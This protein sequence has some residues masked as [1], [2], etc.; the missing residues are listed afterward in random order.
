M[1]YLSLLILPGQTF[2]FSIDHAWNGMECM[3]Y[4]ISHEISLE[5]LTFIN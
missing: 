1:Q 3:W 4:E 5:Y 2:S